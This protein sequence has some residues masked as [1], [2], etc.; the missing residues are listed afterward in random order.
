MSNNPA[1]PLVPIGSEIILAGHRFEVVSHATDRFGRP[2]EV[3]GRCLGKASREQIAAQT[4]RA[5]QNV[6]AAP[7]APSACSPTVSPSPPNTPARKPRQ[8]HRRVRQ[9]RQGSQPYQKKPPPLVIHEEPASIAG[10]LVT[11]AIVLVLAAI[12]WFWSQGSQQAKWEKIGGAAGA[13]QRK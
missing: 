7:Q 13:V 5:G 9:G 10:K 1:S 3:P 6:V 2:C 8:R 4:K 11:L 12:V